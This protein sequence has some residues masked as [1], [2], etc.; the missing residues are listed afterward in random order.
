MTR[1]QALQIVRSISGSVT[2]RAILDFVDSLIELKVLKVEAEP[3]EAIVAVREAI[4]ERLS[5]G[6]ATAAVTAQ[7][8][9]DVLD[10]NGYQIVR[11]TGN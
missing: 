3:P 2:E 4:R 1:Q 6:E 5:C 9:V 11:R 8:V 10:R 7:Y